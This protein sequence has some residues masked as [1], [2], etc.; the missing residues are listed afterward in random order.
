MIEPLTL[1]AVGSV[2]LTEGVKFLYG[3]AAEAI[4][5]WRAR[6]QGRQEVPATTPPSLPATAL[7]GRLDTSSPDLERVG[8][9][10]S[11][12]REL[13]HEIS[14]WAQDLEPID[15]SN[16]GRLASVD[17][18]RRLLESIYG[19]RIT[20]KGEARLPSGTPIVEGEVGV[21]R[22]AGTVAGVD[23][24][25]V[26]AGRIHGI[27]RVRTVE[28]G[29]QAFGVRIGGGKGGTGSAPAPQERPGTESGEG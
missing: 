17:E 1:A 7:E 22:V 27:A 10:E 4:K 18:L 8:R 20:F 29:G 14:D 21:D 15:I 2:V 25:A 5:T 6:Q 16:S 26:P 23:T 13:R 12:L 19:Q 11:R 9:L 28:P 3:Q 24:D